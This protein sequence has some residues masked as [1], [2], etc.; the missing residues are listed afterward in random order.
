MSGITRKI[1]AKPHEI[2]K[3]ATTIVNTGV[4]ANAG[5]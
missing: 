5:I 3:R 2:I 4:Y 1:M